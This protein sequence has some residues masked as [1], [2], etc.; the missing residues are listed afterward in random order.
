MAYAPVGHAELAHVAANC[1]GLSLMGVHTLQLAPADH[2]APSAALTDLSMS[3]HATLARHTFGHGLP[4]TVLELMGACT[5]P[6]D[7]SPSMGL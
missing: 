6:T 2:A 4:E 3:G 5:K 1:P 7:R